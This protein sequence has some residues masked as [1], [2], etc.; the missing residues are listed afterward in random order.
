MLEEVF[1]TNGV[2]LAIKR[3][4]QDILTYVALCVEGVVYIN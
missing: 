4:M 1:L 2:V 3:Y